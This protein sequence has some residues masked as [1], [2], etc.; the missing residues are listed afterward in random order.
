MVRE[1]ER[2][3]KTEREGTGGGLELGWES[4]QFPLIFIYVFGLPVDVK[5]D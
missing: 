2:K 3:S 1:R 5:G 4:S